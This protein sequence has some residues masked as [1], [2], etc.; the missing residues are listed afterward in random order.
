MSRSRNLKAQRSIDI[1]D[2]DQPVPTEL[3]DRDVSRSPPR[4]LLADS[5][6]APDRVGAVVASG[7][8][9]APT[10]DGDILGTLRSL[11]EATNASRAETRSLAVK[12]EEQGRRL[13]SFAG[14]LQDYEMRAK[15]VDD[16]C[17]TLERKVEE[18]SAAVA[19]RRSSSASP[20]VSDSPA[21]HGTPSSDA[22]PLL[23]ALSWTDPLERQ[24]A[25]CALRKELGLDESYVLI[26]PRK[27]AT[28]ALLRT[29]SEAEVTKVLDAARAGSLKVESQRLWV[30]R[31]QSKLQQRSGFLLRRAA[32]YLSSK[33]CEG[34]EKDSRVVYV[35]GRAA[36]SVRD[37]QF[38]KEKGWPETVAGGFEV[39][40]SESK[41]WG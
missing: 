8:V 35:R 17:R 16:R 37:G 30:R 12:I 19:E 28:L 22:D 6:L 15:S 32:A 9:A 2:D 1:S 41:T 5:A 25:D 14:M 34:V 29:K 20:R 27:Y 40:V 39:L 7:S 11:V 33:G 13:D 31:S 36:L 21:T 24:A 23:L 26:F 10:G 3:A 18:L 38:L 4:G